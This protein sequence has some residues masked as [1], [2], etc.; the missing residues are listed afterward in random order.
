MLST[1][2]LFVSS[3][4]NQKIFSKYL[5]ILAV[6]EELTKEL[7]S[8]LKS[9]CNFRIGKTGQTIVNKYNKKYSQEYNFYKVVDHSSKK[10]YYRQS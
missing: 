2:F 5:T 9:M 3:I 7:E 4:I 6:F 10:R 8:Q 1:L